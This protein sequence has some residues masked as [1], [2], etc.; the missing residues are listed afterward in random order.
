MRDL[1]GT[2]RM[3]GRVNAERLDAAPDALLT[4]DEDDAWCDARGRGAGQGRQGGSH[5]RKQALLVVTAEPARSSCHLDVRTAGA[6]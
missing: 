6:V 5:A 3:Y 1:L 4:A 2:G